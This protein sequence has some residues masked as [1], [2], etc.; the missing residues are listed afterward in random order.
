MIEPLLIYAKMG[1]GNYLIYWTMVDY[2]WFYNIVSPGIALATI[3]LVARSA[4]AENADRPRLA[5][6]TFFSI[7]GLLMM[8]KFVNRSIVGV[9]QM[10]SESDMV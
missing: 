2:N 5:L 3:A 10:G 9:W 1:Y 4:K 8:F 6:L 7:C